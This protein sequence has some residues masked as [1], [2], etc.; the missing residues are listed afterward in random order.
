M[1]ITIVIGPFLPIPPVLGGAVEKVHLA[2][3]G[4]YRTA[5]HEVTIIS[6]QYQDFARDEIID[7][8][9]HLRVRA[10][11]RSSSL[12][13][14]LARDLIYALHVARALPAADVTITNAF[15]LP[16][17]LPRRRA[18]KIYVQVG[19]FP[20]RQMSLYFRASRLQAVSQA[21]A[22]AI[23]RQT[24]WLRRKVKV[25]GYAIPEN[26]FCPSPP[27]RREK[28]VLYV[29]RLAREKGVELLVKAFAALCRND[30]VEDT[31]PWKLRIVGPHEISQGGD[32]AAYL[33]QLRTLAVPL[34]SRCE[35]VGPVFDQEELVREYQ[36]SSIF[37]YPS[38]AEFGETLG[39]APLEA[40]AAGCAVVVSNL[41]CFGD[42]LKDE[43]TGVT[44]DHRSANADDS[45]AGQ[46]RRLMADGQRLERIAAA[47]HRAAREF[48][49]DVIAKRML[50][51]FAALL[52]ED[53]EHPVYKPQGRV[54]RL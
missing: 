8:I 38:L 50:G 2:L 42:Y 47:G 1:R 6:R 22:D 36:S 37:V 12:V 13:A 32:G 45:L 15:F 14:N 16:L 51:D 41:P 54:P 52:A 40:M 43:V 9:R 46:L 10:S 53:A 28:T 3:A 11:E 5:G 49:V 48:A 30:Q 19:R 7:G 39:V 33:G 23:V 44:F 31:G 29:G 17:V 21:V 4:A 18:G 20:K 26:Y 25:I 34:G 24:P 27:E 35:F